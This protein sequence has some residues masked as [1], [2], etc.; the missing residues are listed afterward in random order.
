MSAAADPVLT[1]TRLSPVG[2]AVSG[3][4][5]YLI[6]AINIVIL[7]GIVKVVRE[8][9]TGRYDEAG[10]DRELDSRGLMNR[11][12]GRV[13]KA[14]AVTGLS[15][16]VALVIGT[17]EVGGLISSELDLS[18][19]FWNWCENVDL[20]FLGFVIVAMFIATW[21]IAFLVWRLGRIE[22]R[23]STHLGGAAGSREPIA[24]TR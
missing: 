13:T 5:L 4:F 8:M 17:I 20:D 23:W 3:G 10:L 15:V 14:V 6:A 9:R 24:V 1:V 19:S 11:L 2:T 12:F 18:G 16:A 21:V 7:L 22:E